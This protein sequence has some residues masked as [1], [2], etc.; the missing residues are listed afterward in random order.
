MN[1]LEAIGASLSTSSSPSKSQFFR[2][3]V[4]P[5]TYAI[6]NLVG[7]SFVQTP[8]LS[9]LPTLEASTLHLKLANILSQLAHTL[10]FNLIDLLNS[11]KK[12]R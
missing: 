8:S 7:Q 2:N 10:H 5:L 3:K 1:L 4:T 9:Q 12:Y 11:S 6:Q